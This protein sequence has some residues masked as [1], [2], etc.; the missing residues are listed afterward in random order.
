MPDTKFSWTALREHVRKYLWIYIVG[1]AVCLLGTNLLWTTTRPRPDND[2]TVIVFLMDAF[3]NPEALSDVAQDMLERAKADDE[4]LQT[5]EFQSLL[6]TED[7]YMGSMLL[8]TRLTVGEADAFL[9]GQAGMDALVNS[10]ALEPLDDYVAAGWP[11]DFGLE[12]YYATYQDEEA[13]TSTTYL[14]ALKLDGVTALAERGAF[15]NEGAYL[16][17]TANGGNVQTT[18]KA[19]QYMLEDLSEDDHAETGASEPAA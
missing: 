17:V 9:T 13:G 2:E 7:D 10:Q 14:A 5:V 11:G 3:G 16:C 12:P 8:M 19:L 18:M 1:I 15:A 6:Y 4:T